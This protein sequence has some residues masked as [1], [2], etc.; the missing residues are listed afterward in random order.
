MKVLVV[1]GSPKVEKSNTI[2]LTNA[3]VEGIK[4]VHA[5]AEVETLNVKNMQI[6]P[7]LGCMSCWGKTAGKCIIDDVM[8]EVHVKFM[9]AD[10]IIFSFPLYFFGMPGSM[11]VFVDRLM[12]LMETYKGAVKDIG[13]NAFHDFRYDMGNKKYVVVSSCGYGR[14]AEIYDALI[15]EFDF[16]FGKG[17]Y[18]P[19]LCPQSEMFAIPPLKPQ[20]NE[21]LKRYIAVGECLGNMESPSEE[22]IARASEPILPQR[23]FEMLVNNYWNSVTPENPLPAPNLRGGC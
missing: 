12:P 17:R 11:K 8:Q 10:I 23:A 9:E 3:V 19:L 15:R 7:C 22:M 20:I 4:N 16:I 6:Q 1:N 5:D 14:T 2:Q 18:T 13:D 21:Y